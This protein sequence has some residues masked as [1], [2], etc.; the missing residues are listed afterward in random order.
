[1]GEWLYSLYTWSRSHTTLHAETWS[2]SSS[3]RQ[4]SS[5]VARWGRRAGSQCQ[6]SGL[7]GTA[8]L[9]RCRCTAAWRIGRHRWGTCRSRTGV[10]VEVSTAAFGACELREWILPCSASCTYQH[11][12]TDISSYV[13]KDAVLLQVLTE[14]NK[15]RSW[16][17]NSWSTP[18]FKKLCK[19]VFCQISTDFDNFWQKDGKEVETMQGVLIFHLN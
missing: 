12:D 16:S 5:V 15:I 7:A 19:I 3:L 8:G 9:P 18:C 6:G 1:M 10:E 4:P 11:Q 2:T 17:C 13:A 14:T